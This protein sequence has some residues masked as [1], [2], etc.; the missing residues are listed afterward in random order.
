MTIG[1]EVAMKKLLAIL[2]LGAMI[3]SGCAALSDSPNPTVTSYPDVVS[4]ETAVE[5]LNR[6]EVE[7]VVQRHNLEVTLV[8]KNGASINTVEPIIDAIFQEVDKCD[9]P[10]KNIILATE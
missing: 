1:K 8:L 6:G 7:T 9:Q 5:I 10:C 2:A 3:I 4:W